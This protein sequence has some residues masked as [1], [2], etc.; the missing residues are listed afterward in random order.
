M[1]T[2]LTNPKVATCECVD[3]LWFSVYMSTISNAFTRIL[4]FALFS[5]VNWLPMVRQRNVYGF[6]FW[7]KKEGKNFNHSDS[8]TQGVLFKFSTHTHTS[9]FIYHR[10]RIWDSA[11]N[12][13]TKTDFLLSLINGIEQNNAFH[14]ERI[15][16]VC[17]MVILCIQLKYCSSTILIYHLI[18]IAIDGLHF[19]W[20]WF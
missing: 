6:Q 20:N 7:Y 8:A 19:S 5:C 11:K 18:I 17:Y 1:S 16:V 12:P 10:L 3:R 2:K 13:N 15:N 14:H 4:F 9:L